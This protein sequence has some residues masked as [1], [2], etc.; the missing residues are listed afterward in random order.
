MSENAE[1]IN[2][3]K[4]CLNETREMVE[5]YVDEIIGSVIF[6]HESVGE[7]KE[8][9]K[10]VEADVNVDVDAN[11]DIK[12]VEVEVDVAM[13]VKVDAEVDDVAVHR[14]TVRFDDTHMHQKKKGLLAVCAWSTPALPFNSR[15]EKI[16]NIH[17]KKNK[18]NIPI[19]LGYLLSFVAGT[20]CG[21]YLCRRK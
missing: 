20:L 5:K 6:A 21:I 7:I 12:V 9:K 1:N 13:D 11:T 15:E 4:V 14:K 19:V 3:D 18:K 2:T 8:N 10:V 17:D 16:A